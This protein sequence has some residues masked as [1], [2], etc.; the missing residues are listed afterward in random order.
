M[1]LGRTKPIVPKSICGIINNISG[2]SGKTRSVSEVQDQ[3]WHVALY[4]S[5]RDYFCSGALIGNQ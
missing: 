1:S 5:N 2:L 3:C 4:N